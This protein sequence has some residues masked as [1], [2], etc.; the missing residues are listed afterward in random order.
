MTVVAV[1]LAV[2]ATVAGWWLSRQRLRALPW[3]EI[4]VGAEFPRTQAS[5]V[6]SAKLGVGLFIAVATG[7]FALL[8][9]AYLMRIGAGTPDLATG[10]QQLPPR[11]LWVNTGAL[12]AASAALQLASGAARRGQRGIVLAN[13]IAAA[14]ATL[15]FVAGQLLAWRML[16]QAGHPIASSTT[17]AFFYTLTGAHGLHVLGGLVGLGRTLVKALR[18][19]GLNTLRLPVQLCAWYWH[20]LLLVWLAVFALLMGGADAFADFCRALVT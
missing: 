14:V 6:P 5:P 4:G 18:G 17:N 20:F 19:A 10:A 3:L 2:V 9:S 11:L 1:F 15:A 12:V 16:T 8:F 13:L 7:L